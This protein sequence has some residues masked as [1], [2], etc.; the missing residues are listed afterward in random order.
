MYAIGVDPGSVSGAVAVL[1]DNGD[2][3]NVEPLHTDTNFD[4]YCQLL[5]LV[6]AA[7]STTVFVEAVGTSRPGNSSKAAHTFA[8]H[9][10]ALN[11]ALSIILAG[12]DAALVRPQKWMDEL[13]GDTYPHGNDRKAER[14]TFI[15]DWVVTNVPNPFGLKITKKCADA[16]AIA[17]FCW[18]NSRPQT[19]R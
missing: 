18:Q 4:L 16:V 9:V 1:N 14:K 5:R 6:L 8:S 10:G 15:Y 2:L 19:K 17:Y 11:M 12:K 3:V 7:H 13:F